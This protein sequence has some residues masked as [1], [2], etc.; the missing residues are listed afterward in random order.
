MGQTSPEQIS[1]LWLRRYILIGY[2]AK[3]TVYLLIGISAIQAAIFR[4]EATGTYLSLT[5]LASQPFGKLLVFLLA[6]ALMGYVLRRIFQTIHVPGNSQSFKL[7]VP[8]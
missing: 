5:S 4:Q 8:V 3:G 6:I 1:N 2:A 7:E